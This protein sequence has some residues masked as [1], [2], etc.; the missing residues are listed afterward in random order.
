MESRWTEQDDAGEP[1]GGWFSYAALT[2]DAGAGEPLDDA[3]TRFTNP[4]RFLPLHDWALEAVARLQREYEVVREEGEGMD[5]LLERVP[6]AKP[7]IRLT[8]LR[9]D[10]API[11]IGIHRLSRS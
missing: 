5:A 8:P 3:Y 10:G 1:G 4:E 9:D 6:L 11:T 2:G 7:T